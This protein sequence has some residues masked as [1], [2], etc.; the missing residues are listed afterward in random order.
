MSKNVAARSSRDL[1][2]AVNFMDAPT[3]QNA[4]LSQTTSQSRKNAT[5]AAAI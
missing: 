2:G 5:S 1:A 3:I 4:T